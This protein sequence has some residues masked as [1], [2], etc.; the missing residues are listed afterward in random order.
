MWV[1]SYS[2]IY[3]GVKKE[4]IWRLWADVNNWPKWDKELEYCKMEGSF[5]EGNHF[6]LKPIDGPKVR[7]ILS[8]VINNKKFTDYAKF[9]GAIMYDSHELEETPNGLLIT[10]TITVKGFLS[11]IWGRLVAKG[12]AASV[13]KQLDALVELASARS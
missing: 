12:V 10:S 11:F 1:K 13:P 3:K 6:I 9:P 7:I 8:E 2:K 5:S 4:D